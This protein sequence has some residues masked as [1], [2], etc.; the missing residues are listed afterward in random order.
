VMLSGGGVGGEE[1][2]DV[3]GHPLLRPHLMVQLRPGVV[4]SQVGDQVREPL[5]GVHDTGHLHAIFSLDLQCSSEV[6]ELGL[7]GIPMV[8][9]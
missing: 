9:R 5:D 6:S 2:C 8:S 1:R 7:G 4:I 3:H